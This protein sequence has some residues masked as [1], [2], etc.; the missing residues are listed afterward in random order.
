[1]RMETAFLFDLDGTLVDSVYQHVLAWKEALDTEG[2]ELSVWR[3]HRK[4]GMSGGLFTNQLLRE[5]GGDISQERVDRLR[6]THA[7]AYKRLRAQVCPLPGAR[8]LLATLTQTGTRWAIATSGRME[9]AAVNLEALGVD[10]SKEV[11][12]TRDD[13]K[14][15]KPDPDLF[16]A[17]AARLGVPVEQSVV[18]GDSIWD[19]LAARRCRALGVGLLSGGYGLD[20]L[21]RSGALRVYE[22]P[23]D[24]LLH[25]D[26][27]AA[28]P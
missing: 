9:T 20:E 21:E 2:I 19:M 16:I 4:I 7:E 15:A 3:I 10:P 13:V 27:V 17:A 28:R 12:V 24:L 22:D 1:M 18:V 26:E 11:V 25:L 8:E 6:R 23:H 5:T 14:Y